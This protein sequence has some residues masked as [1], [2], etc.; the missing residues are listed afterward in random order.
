MKFSEDR[1]HEIFASLGQKFVAIVGDIM[2]DRYI[3]GEVT[4]I[5]PEAPVP[6]VD[7]KKESMHMGG[8][9]NVALNI[10]SLGAQPV[11]FGAVG[12]DANAG[13]LR[14]LCTEAEIL[15]DFIVVDEA[16]PTT[17]KTRI[18]AGSQHVVRIDNED[19]HSISPGAVQKLAEMLDTHLTS[20]H[21]IILQDYNKGVLGESL[22]QRVLSVAIKRGIPVLVDPKYHHFFAYQGV[23]V[24]KPNRKET[25]DA[26]GIR[27]RNEEDFSRAANLLHDRISCENILLTLGEHGMLLCQKD[28]TTVR[29]PT[30]ARK[31]ADV[32]GAGDTVIAT[33]AAA[34]ASGA[35]VVEAAHLANF[36]GGLVC[37]EVGI[38]PV[39]RNALLDAASGRLG[40]LE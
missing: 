38:V 19:R 9:S 11:L 40:E 7:V 36:A 32:S 31:V 37:E 17:V 12:D 28:G 39:K 15:T 1:L 18:I 35:S 8:A 10:R 13:D 16:R 23:T 34:V 14:R 4:R 3:W 21:A 6:V 25:E 26:L 5:S 33:L 27:L 30:R 20:I 29:I 2:L 22:I 24:F